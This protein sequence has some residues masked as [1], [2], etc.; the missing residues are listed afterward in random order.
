MK[1]IWFIALLLLLAACK[2]EDPILTTVQTSGFHSVEINSFFNVYLQE[3]TVFYVEVIGAEEFVNAVKIEVLDSVL[4]M[5]SDAKNNWSNPT[6][7]QVKIIVHAPP[8]KLVTVNETASV[9]T[10][11]PI[12]SQEFGLIMKSKSNEANLELDCATFY[13]WNNFPTGGSLTLHGHA[14]DLKI[15]NTAILTV[16][17]RDLIAQYAHVENDAKADCIITVT[18]KIEYKLTNQ[19]NIHVYGAPAYFEEI[20]HTGSGALIV[21]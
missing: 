9:N 7:K 6:N 21:H 12:T 15:W 20:E 5:H 2:K 3:D 18:Q 19:G 1:S 14:H 8:L 16:N 13:Y 11:N 10:I 4:V 17:A